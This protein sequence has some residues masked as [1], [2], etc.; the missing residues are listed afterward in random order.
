[1]SLTLIGSP[2]SPFVRKVN[3]VLLEKGLDFEIEPVSPFAP[4]EDF[5]DTSPLG[6][7]P[8]LRHDERIVND[9][10]VI[11]RYLDRIAP[12][13]PLYPSDPFDA[14]RAEWIEEFVDGGVSPVAGPGIFQP[15][16]LRPMMSG[17][18][19]DEAAAQKVLDQDMPPLFGYLE[20]Q[21]GDEEFF[22]A[23]ALSV[24]DISVASLFVNLRLAGVA[25][26][27]NRWPALHAFT[28]RMHSRESF[29]SVIAP[30]VEAIGKRWVE[31]D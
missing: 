27:R 26:D 15:L 5:R 1:M 21:L 24:A 11:A 19:P 16:V 20:E 29:K 28:R 13:P 22:V 31:L 25:P 30:V 6:K 4:P 8:A 7:I 2:V 14:A 9:S 12:N 23:G 18:E 17:V 10:S 3:V